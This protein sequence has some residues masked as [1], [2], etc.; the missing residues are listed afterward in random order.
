MDGGSKSLNL[1][2]GANTTVDQLNT[3]ML[4]EYNMPE[5]PYG[6]IFTIWI[7]SPS[8]ELQLKPEHKP[9]EQINS[10]KRRI[11]G[12]LT[13][14][15]PK[16]EEAIL[17]WRRNAKISLIV[18]REVTHPDAIR[19]L[20][21]EAEFNYIN[22]FYPCKEQ[23]VWLFASILLFLKHGSQDHQAKA[24]LNRNLQQLVPVPN[25]KKNSNLSTKILTQ[26]RELCNGLTEGNNTRIRLQTQFLNSCRNLT[27]YGSAFFT[28]GLQSSK[29]SA[30]DNVKCYVAVNDVGIHII[31]YQSRLM[32]HSFKY[33]EITWQLPQEYGILELTVVNLRGEVR[34]SDRHLRKPLKLITKQAGMIN[35]LMKKLSRMQGCGNPIPDLSD[36][37]NFSSGQLDFTGRVVR[38]PV[39][40]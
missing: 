17:K 36:T 6:D 1:S 22:A 13:D 4:R 20:F 32:L 10:W 40:I 18:E 14:G 35:H 8:L 9:L 28:G 23:D 37:G 38:R 2:D 31:N 21:Y 27:V 30:K 26:Y 34:Q 29:P 5:T 3:Q 12:N 16:K 7:C 39:K 33:S 19:L 11:V 15:D 24:F 25:L